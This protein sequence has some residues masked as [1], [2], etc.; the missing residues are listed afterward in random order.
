MSGFSVRPFFA[1]DYETSKA[2]LF[3]LI[4]YEVCVDPRS[5]E[6][7]ERVLAFH[8]SRARNVVTSAPARTSKSFSAAPEIVHDFFPD[9]EPFTGSSKNV[10][11]WNGMVAA[12]HETI[13]WIV[14]IAY[15]NAKEWDYART[16]LIDKK[17]IEGIGGILENDTNSPNQGNMTIKVR[18]PFTDKNGVPA[19][20]I[21]QVKSSV[22]EK[23]LQ[24]E[25]VKTAI[26]SEAAEHDKRIYEKYLRTRCGRI[27][28]PTTPKRKALWLYELFQ[29]GKEDTSL[30]IEHFQ[31]DRFCNPKYDHAGYE[32]AKKIANLTY[33]DYREDPA[34]MEQYE[35]QWTFEGGKVLPFRWFD[36]GRAPCN[37]TD[38]FPDWINTATWWVTFD[39]GWTDPAVALLVAISPTGEMFVASEIYERNLTTFDLVERVVQ[40]NQSL[41]LTPSHYVPDPQKPELTEI[42]RR[43][44]LNL[45]NRAP[46]NV[47]R[48]RAAGYAA[49]R[50]ILSVD[51]AIGRPRLTIYR[52]CERMITEFKEVRFKD[53]YAD[54]HSTGSIVGEDHTIDA[55][56]YLLMSYPKAKPKNERWIDQWTQQQKLIERFQKREAKKP[57]SPIYHETY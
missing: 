31:F 41:G 57:Y 42:I 49:L 51:P 22:N 27:I 29:R 9:L 50:D 55:M 35:G 10:V 45:F 48:D 39:Y 43:R 47:V 7:A 13:C 46:A 20:S 24:G 5:P 15:D 37:V 6:S 3:K 1:A 44:G 56:R 23:T 38:R 16:A 8:R 14:A 12:T 21:L 17:L 28:F 18:W 54:E 33:G 4:G 34:F 26:M 32:T 52:A 2:I 30:N 19:R 25:Q 40:R 36:D 53:N 11:P